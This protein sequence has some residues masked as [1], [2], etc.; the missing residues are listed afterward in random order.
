MQNIHEYMIS[1]KNSPIFT[2]RTHKTYTQFVYVYLYTITQIYD[3]YIIM[4]I[5]STFELNNNIILLFSV[6]RIV[7][8]Q[9]NKLYANT[10]IPIQS[11]AR[12]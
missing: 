12:S 7:M 4:T 3:I 10:A 6:M 8:T 1:H 11:W 9:I 5:F 2:I